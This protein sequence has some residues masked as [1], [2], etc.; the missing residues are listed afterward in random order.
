MG[1]RYRKRLPI[2]KT[3]GVNVSRRGLSFSV[4]IPG[5][6]LWWNSGQWRPG[7][8]GRA[9]EAAAGTGGSGC[10]GLLAIAAIG[11]AGYSLWPA[12]STIAPVATRAVT[13]SMEA[14]IVR[15]PTLN[16][17]MTRGPSVVISGEPRSKLPLARPEPAPV[18]Q[19]TKG[20]DA[21]TLL[22]M[23]RNLDALNPRAAAGYFREVIDRFPGSSEAADAARRLRRLAR[24]GSP[25]ATGPRE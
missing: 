8:G 2:G 16:P 24:E 19:K 6:G 9:K 12:P 15:Q 25:P 4:R 21:A 22:K 7:S 17:D 5:T 11:I 20:P 10:L 1:W 23:G 13:P 18:P 14:A 3:A